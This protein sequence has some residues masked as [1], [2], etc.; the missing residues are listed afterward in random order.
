MHFE[1]NVSGHIVL[2]VVAQLPQRCLHGAIINDTCEV[3]EDLNHIEMLLIN[4]D[5]ST[6]ENELLI[7]AKTFMFSFHL[8]ILDTIFTR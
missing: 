8:W 2:Y 3:S 1:D 4:I 6:V 5:V 7:L